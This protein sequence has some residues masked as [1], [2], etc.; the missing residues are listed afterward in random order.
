MK[1]F[2]LNNITMI[3]ILDKYNIK[4]KGNQ[5]VCPF[6]NDKMPSAKA[7]KNSFYCFAC[8]KTG[9][10]IQF[11]E[12]YFNIDF[13]SAIK[14]INK[15][16]NLNLSFDY[17]KQDLEKYKKERLLLQK[18]KENKIKEHNNK[19]INICDKIKK[20]EKEYIKLKSQLNPY[21]WE[22][23]EDKSSI[24]WEKIQI[25]EDEFDKLNIK[26]DSF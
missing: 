4:R 26:K 14:T 19:M 22:E 5:F 11:V 8:N 18:E 7:Y 10:L 15:D 23:I 3:E 24:I 21:N 17:N 20:L 2:I 9:D 12:Y 25:Y 6:H 13:I 1:D 16:F